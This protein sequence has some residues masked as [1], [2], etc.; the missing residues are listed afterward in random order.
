MFILG[1]IMLTGRGSFF[2]AGYNTKSKSKKEMYDATALSK[3]AG[4]IVLPLAILVA[5]VGIEQLNELSWF[6]IA[7]VAVFVVI[8]AFAIIYANTGN[9]F[10][11]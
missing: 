11:R 2:I 9:R 8:L 3:F 1:I 6:W 5:L 4:K 10:K 7:W